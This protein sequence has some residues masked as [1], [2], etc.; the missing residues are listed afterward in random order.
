MKKRPGLAHFFK[1]NKMFSR[2]YFNGAKTYKSK[3]GMKAIRFDLSPD[4]L[5]F[6]KTLPIRFPKLITI[7]NLYT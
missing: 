1:R 7:T 5:D 4:R 2:K 6:Q 3:K